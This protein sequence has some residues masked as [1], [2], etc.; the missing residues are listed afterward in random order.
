VG[1][2]EAF[3]NELIE[4]YLE[5]APTMIGEMEQAIGAGEAAALRMAAHTLKSNS[6]DFGSMELS[7]L[8]KNLEHIGREGSVDGAADLMAEVKAQFAK[9][10]ASLEKIMNK[11]VA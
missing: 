6:A 5:D 7:E 3:L 1:D 10:K 4:T 2:D 11:D 8:A 9:T